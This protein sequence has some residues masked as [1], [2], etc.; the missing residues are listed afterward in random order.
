MNPLWLTVAAGLWPVFALAPGPE[1]APVLWETPVSRAE[2]SLEPNLLRLDPAVREALDAASRTRAQDG[3][4]AALAGLEKAREPALVLLRAALRRATGHLAEAQADYEKVLAS[5]D[6]STLRALA[7]S[8]LKAV[9]R[10]R[11]AEGE[12][13]CCQPLLRLLKEEWLNEE[14]LELVAAIYADPEAPAEAKDYARS[15]EP[16]L[17]LRLG[18]YDQAIALWTSAA[19]REAWEIRALSEA[20]LRRGRFARAAELRD[21]P[22]AFTILA[23]GGLYQKALELADKHPALKK[24]PD[25]AWRLGLA[26][27]AEKNWAAAQDWLEPLTKSGDRQAGAWYFLGRTLDGAGQKENARAAYARAAQGP[28][29]YYQILAEGRLEKIA[30][31]SDAPAAPGSDGYYRISPEGRLQK[32]A[33]PLAETRPPKIWGPLLAPGPAGQ[34][35]DS[36]GFHLWITEKG[37]SGPGLDKAADELLAAGPVLAG[38]PAAAQLNETLADLLARRDWAGLTGLRRS[39]PGAFKNFTPAARDLWPPLAASAA[40]RAGD[41]QLALS[42]LASFKGDDRPGLKKWGYPLVYGRPVWNAWRNHALAP[43]LLLALIRTESAY[44]ADIISASNARGLMQLLPATAAKV[45][46][47][48]NEEEPGPLALFEPDLNIRYGSWYL[49]AL[50][51]GFGHE[52][53]ALAGYNGGPYNIKSLMAAKPAMP[54][55][56]FIE[57]LPSEETV[58]YVKRIIERRYIYEM[59]YLG[60]AVRPD[61]SG[62]LPPPRPSLPDF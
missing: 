23:K 57:S 54:L 47:A 36:L 49:A 59:V 41:Y 10:Q 35:R 2:P 60:R 42:L 17:A 34:D 61:L 8:G 37:F 14:A 48:L 62:P 33:P 22:A 56:V 5:P 28:A 26:A 53:L 9:L 38:G 27:L 4:A 3:P 19:P 52:A 51:E 20:E 11:L 15:Q 1:P 13:I 58:N 7:L 50:I 46:R 45:A 44:Q 18:R 25:Y 21:H 40:A 24:S 31:V 55:D 43:A 29:G 32:A 6:R 12:K 16:L 39:R 30:P